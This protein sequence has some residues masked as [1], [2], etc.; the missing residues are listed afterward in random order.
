[1]FS[2]LEQLTSDNGLNDN[3][4]DDY[5]VFSLVTPYNHESCP[6]AIHMSLQTSIPIP[7]NK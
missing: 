1:M 3:G 5:S 4:K 6:T 7:I 2:V